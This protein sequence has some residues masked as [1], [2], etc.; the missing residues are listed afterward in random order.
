MARRRDPAKIDAVIAAAS[1]TLIREGFDRMKVQLVA[2][3]AK[4]SP[5]TVY[6]YVED[7]EALL[8]LAVLRAL[9]S[10]LAREP[11]LPYQKTDGNARRALLNDCLKEI[12][13]FPQLWVGAQRRSLS[14]TREEYFGILLELCRWIRRY[15]TAILLADRNRLFW[16]ALAE[17]FEKVVWSDLHRRLTGY[18]DSRIRAG[19]LLPAG[20]PAMV[21]RFTLDALVAVLVTGPLSLPSEFGQVEDEVVAGL[22]GAGLIGSRDALPFPPH[23]GQHPSV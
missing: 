19:R 18:L 23:P 6:L 20:D 1:D 10:P 12:L 13:H 17:E 4:V 15:R 8:E 22:V 7:K 5:G 3:A 16:P 9:E 14:E 2:Q 21:A 11:H